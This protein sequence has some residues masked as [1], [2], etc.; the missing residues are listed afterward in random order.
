MRVL[1]SIILRSI[2]LWSVKKNITVSFK[3]TTMKGYKTGTE[4]IY[5]GWHAIYITLIL[6]CLL[7]E[8]F[9]ESGF[10]YFFALSLIPQGIF[11]VL[12]GIVALLRPEEFRLR[13]TYLLKIW[14]ILS[15]IDLIAFYL[16][17]N[18][19]MKLFGDFNTWPI[20]LIPIL[21]FVQFIA[22]THRGFKF[23]PN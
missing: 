13:K 18:L 16:I 3:I 15:L 5:L 9:Y 1:N 14:A 22:L 17:E 8:L 21:P 12:L 10:I 6:I 2:K 19:N 20:I 4:K 7:L 23:N 11:Q